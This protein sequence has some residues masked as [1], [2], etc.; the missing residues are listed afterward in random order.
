MSRTLSPCCRLFVIAALFTKLARRQ[1]WDL[2]VFELKLLP[3][4]LS[5]AYDGGFMLSLFI[6]E[7]QTANTN[8]YSLRFDPRSDQIAD[9]V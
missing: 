3:P 1:L 4:Y 8:F 6:T 5:M 9:L 7:L 2:A